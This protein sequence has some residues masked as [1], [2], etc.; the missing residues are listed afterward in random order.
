MPFPPMH[1]GRFGPDCRSTIA[2]PATIVAASY[3]GTTVHYELE[4]AGPALHAEA[5][6]S[7]GHDAV[8][9]RRR[10]YACWKTADFINLPCSLVSG[11]SHSLFP[12][13]SDAALH[14]ASLPAS[15]GDAGLWQ[16]CGSGGPDA[17]KFTL[18]PCIADLSG[19]VQSATD[20][21]DALLSPSPRVIPGAR[22]S[23]GA[24]YAPD[25]TE[26]TQHRDAA[27]PVATADQRRRAH[28]RMG[29][30]A[31]ATRH[32]EQ[33]ADRH[34]PRP[35]ALIYNDYG[36]VIGLTHVFF[37][38]MALALMTSLYRDRRQSPA[39]GKQSR[40]QP[41]GYFSRNHLPS[42]P[43]RHARGLDSGLHNERQHLCDP[44][45]ARRHG[46]QAD[47]NGDLRSCDQLSGMA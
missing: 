22:L 27:D 34:R 44:G 33:R 37:G 21:A 42:E 6:V 18:E 35:V 38:Y 30:P 47:G 46:K 5:P 10:V 14:W 8:R 3:L 16:L 15:G 19:P 41:L 4:R 31:W 40:R 7:G 17:G 29:H 39:G 25:V 9:P 36:V 45:A 32:H 28:P 2:C 1:R 23:G 12:Q 20:F 13:R 24:A 43:P 11:R 26:G